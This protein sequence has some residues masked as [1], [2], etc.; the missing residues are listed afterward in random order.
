MK[1]VIIESPFAGDVYTNVLYLR[2]CMNYALH[3]EA[4]PYASHGLYPQPG[5]LRDEIKK[6]RKLGMRAGFEWS[7]VADEVWVFTDLGVTQGMLDGIARHE[8][9]GFRR[10]VPAD[11]RASL[12]GRGHDGKK[13]IRFKCLSDDKM[14]WMGYLSDVLDHSFPPGPMTPIADECVDMLADACRRGALFAH[15]AYA[16][17]LESHAAGKALNAILDVIGK[18]TMAIG[19]NE[20]KVELESGLSFSLGVKKLKKKKLSDEDLR[21]FKESIMKFKGKANGGQEGSSKT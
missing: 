6:E 9:N 13:L 8:V 17:Q 5:V 14:G 18:H 19:V 16:I 21:R 4:S 1:K 15:D 11:D 2:A 12:N 10:A 20:L 3:N 7:E